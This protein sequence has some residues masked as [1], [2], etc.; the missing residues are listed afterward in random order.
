M[1]QLFSNILSLVPLLGMLF[2]VAI[3]CVSL[4]NVSRGCEPNVPG[5]FKLYLIR[6]DEVT[7]IPAAV[8]QTIST[9]LT[10]VSGKGF[11]VWEFTEETAKV[12]ENAVGEADGKSFEDLIDFFIPG[13]DATKAYQFSQMLNDRFIAIT[14]DGNNNIKIHGDLDRPMRLE[15]QNFTTGAAN[16]DRKG[17]AFQLKC[18]ASHK[19][20]WYTGTITTL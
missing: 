10:L 8:Y 19:A 13:D 20:Y 14:K 1:E 16:A 3:G 11:S 15:T 17:T 6:V 18:N 2:L 12:D 9:N 7:T 5:L 4:A